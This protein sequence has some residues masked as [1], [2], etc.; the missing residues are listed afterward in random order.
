MQS[1]ISFIKENIS[2]IETVHYVIVFIGVVVACIQLNRN[3]RA[4]QDKHSPILIVYSPKD[5]DYIGKLEAKNVGNLPAYKIRIYVYRANKWFS[6][7]YCKKI[8][9]TEIS[10]LE[11][12]CKESIY[13]KPEIQ[14]ELD[15]VDKIKIKIKYYSPFRNR[16]LCTK[17]IAKR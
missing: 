15:S 4:N 17:H 10:E 7:F 16:K 11:T 1:L 8:D 2:F 5:A 14:K 13:S 9:S 12:G 3:I 6:F